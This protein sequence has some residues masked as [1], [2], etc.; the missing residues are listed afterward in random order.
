MILQSLRSSLREDGSS[1]RYPR[2]SGAC[3][4][5]QAVTHHIPETQ[6]RHGRDRVSTRH[7]AL[8]HPLV[9]LLHRDKNYSGIPDA[10]T[11]FVVVSQH[12]LLALNA[13]LSRRE[14]DCV[15]S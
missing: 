12:V 8:L 3:V 10:C 1:Q 9:L 2:A 14:R 5:L 15:E 4:L 6:I 13:S 7:L 11:T